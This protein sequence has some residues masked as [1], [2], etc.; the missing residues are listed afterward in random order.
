MYQLKARRQCAYN[1]TLSRVL[2]AIVGVEKQ[3]VL[4]NLCVD[5]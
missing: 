2:T 1:V 5:L 4:Y 3:W